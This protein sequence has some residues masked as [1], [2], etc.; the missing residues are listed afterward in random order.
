MNT[1]SHFS[2]SRKPVAQGIYSF[3]VFAALL[4]GVSVSN[5][6][7]D[8]TYDATGTGTWTNSGEFNPGG[9]GT[10]SSVRYANYK[11]NFAYNLLNN[12]KQSSEWEGSMFPAYNAVDGSTFMEDNGVF[13][14]NNADE[15]HPWW[16]LKVSTAEIANLK[17]LSSVAIY[18]RLGYTERL[19]DFTISIY[20]VDPESEG[21]TAVWT[22]DS[23]TT[24]PYLK[25]IGIDTT[26]V[27]DAENVWIRVTNHANSTSKEALS[28][29]DSNFSRTQSIRISSIR[30]FTAR[31]S[32]KENSTSRTIS[33]RRMTAF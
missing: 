30:T 26:G 24:F 8:P 28:M 7:A 9:A 2:P 31:N 21:A 16:Q 19:D 29:S 33:S 13:T 5:L 25:N 15:Q 18:Q 20:T 4:S 14:H 10:T 12:A 22:S 32:W 3:M 1:K 6:Q 23:Q 27:G 17:D 11:Q